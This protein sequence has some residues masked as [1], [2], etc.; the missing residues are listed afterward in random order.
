M[1]GEDVAA[2][3]S[4]TGSVSNESPPLAPTPPATAPALL[5]CPPLDELPPV[6]P[7]SLDPGACA[8]TGPAWNFMPSEK[9]SMGSSMSLL[10]ASAAASE[11]LSQPGHTK[12]SAQT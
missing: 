12:H 8:V 1:T 7:A 5:C 9:K 6:A 2:G 10:A 3:V 11:G 4:N